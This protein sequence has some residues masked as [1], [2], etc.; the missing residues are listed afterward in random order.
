MRECTFQKMFGVLRRVSNKGPHIQTKS[1]MRSGLPVAHSLRATVPRRNYSAPGYALESCCSVLNLSSSTPQIHNN[2]E[3]EDVA[4]IYPDLGSICNIE[5]LQ[6]AEPEA[7]KEIWEKYHATKYCISGVIPKDI[8]MKLRKR[9]TK[10]PT[11]L[12]PC[13]SHW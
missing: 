10:Y 5:L 11:F 7:I 3:L 2:A 13:A 6:D 12:I 9:W 4:K 8:Y 1:C